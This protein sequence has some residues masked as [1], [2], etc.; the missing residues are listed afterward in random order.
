MT[1][2]GLLAAHGGLLVDDVS[3]PS[4]RDVIGRL[5]SACAHAEIAVSHVRLGAVDLSAEE[6]QGVQMC[7]V[8]L[9]RLEAR[10]FDA[11]DAVRTAAGSSGGLLEFI[12][13]DRVQ[14]HSV[15]FGCWQPDFSI[16]R[17]IEGIGDVLLVGAHYFHEPQT[18]NGSAFTCIVTNAVAVSAAL[19]R[20]NRLWDQSH[21]V[22]AVVLAGLESHA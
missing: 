11:I 13:S 6:M 8:L 1:L 9:D 10:S 4:L 12:A 19:A 21:D 17:G 22:R 2:E 15:G 7:R 18:L 5:L 3:E 16:Y 14:T 20:F